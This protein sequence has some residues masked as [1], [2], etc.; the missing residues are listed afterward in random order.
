VLTAAQRVATLILKAIAM[1]K[2]PSVR[3]QAWG[4]LSRRRIASERKDGFGVERKQEA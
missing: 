3:R 2:Y 1:V 4:G